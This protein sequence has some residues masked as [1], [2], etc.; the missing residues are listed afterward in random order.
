[1]KQTCANPACGKPLGVAAG[2]PEG[3]LAFCGAGCVQRWLLEHLPVTPL[4][5]L[6][7]SMVAGKLV[8]IVAHHHE[9]LED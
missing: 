4:Y 2:C 3:A 1:M 7:A 5:D 9:S 8:P 6:E